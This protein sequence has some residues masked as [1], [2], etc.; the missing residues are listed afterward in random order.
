MELKQSISSHE[1]VIHKTPVTHATMGVLLSQK[2][3]L[4]SKCFVKVWRL[5]LLYYCITIVALPYTLKYF[6]LLLST[7]YYRALPPLAP[8]PLCLKYSYGGH[9]TLLYPANKCE[10]DLLYPR[11]ITFKILSPAIYKSD[12]WLYYRFGIIWYNARDENLTRTRA[13]AEF[14]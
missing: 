10:Y 4:D 11:Q 7:H 5:R 12:D 14:V 6:F 2:Q 9:R 1:E 8:L 13:Q 3:Q